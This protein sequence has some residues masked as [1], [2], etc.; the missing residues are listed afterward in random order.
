LE[1][2]KLGT[3][4]QLSFCLLA[5][6]SLLLLALQALFLGSCTTHSSNAANVHDY[7]YNGLDEAQQRLV[8]RRA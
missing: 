1:H 8:W 6:L 7:M 3:A 4:R 2:K 5:S